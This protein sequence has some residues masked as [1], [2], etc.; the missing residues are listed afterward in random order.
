[1]SQPIKTVVIDDE[2]LARQNLKMFLEEYCPELDVVAEAGSK[3]GGLDII[4]SYKP[5]IVFLD[6][7]MPS[8]AEG[9]ELLEEID[10]HDFKV[11]FVTA[12][13][14]YAIKAFKANAIDYILKPID[15]DELQEA[16]KKTVE[17][18]QKEKPEDNIGYQQK[19]HNFARGYLSDKITISHSKGIKIVDP[20]TI[21]HIEADNSYSTI[22]FNDGSSFVDSKTLKHYESILPHQFIRIHKSH[23]INLDY[24]EE[25]SNQDGHFAIMKNGEMISI[26]RNKIR[27]F[28]EQLR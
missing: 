13:K 7:R 9:F 20:K 8:G 23:I 22:Y 3:Q 24:L 5:K 4:S 10:T 6:I 1:M 27:D 12:F 28:L 11:I 26:S 21:T 17:S 19:I 25:Y 15:I 16:V 14:D 2:L 18:I